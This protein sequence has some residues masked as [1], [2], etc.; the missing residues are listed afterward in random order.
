MMYQATAPG[1]RF[2]RSVGALTILLPTAGAIATAATA[3]AFGV[4]R[5]DV[6]LLIVGYVLSIV[7]VE[8]GY[9]RMVVHRGFKTHGMT[10]AILA[11]VGSMG[12]IGPIGWWTA[13]HRQHHEFT[14]VPGDP[15]SPHLS[16]AGV[17]GRL[18]GFWHSHAGWLTTES[19][20][21][22]DPARYAADVYRDPILRT[23]HELYFPLV[24]AGLLIPSIAGALL[25]ASWTGAIHGLLWGGLT[26]IFCVHH[27][28][29]ALGSFCHLYGTQEY[30]TTDAARNNVW[31]AI[32]TFGEGW[33]HNHH[34]FPSSARHGLEWWQ[35]DLNYWFIRTLELVGLAWDVKVPSR[36]AR[37]ARR[38]V[39]CR[40]VAN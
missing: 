23:V 13:N 20:I 24:F 1:H 33:H 2:E 32:P 28:V 4:D 26:R 3:L 35:I 22:T 36:H 15:H 39:D 7:A 29:W 9:H 25:H 6:G 16:G 19:S 34:A 31:V 14:D 11:G 18:R 38:R 27:A 17:L 40:H 5:A 8:V 21:V 37:D 12:A 10:R 30:R